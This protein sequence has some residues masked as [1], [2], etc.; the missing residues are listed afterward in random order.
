[1]GRWL[2]ARAKKSTGDAI[3]ALMGL[4]ANTARVLRDGQEID[5]PIEQVAV[6]DIVRFAPARRCRSM[7]RDVGHLNARRACSRAKAF[8]SKNGP[9]TGDRRDDQRS[10]SFLFRRRRSDRIPRSRRLSALVE[11][12]QG[13]KAPMQRLADRISGIFVPVV[14]IAALTFGIWMLVGPERSLY[15]VTATVAV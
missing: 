14:L 8:R 10:G 12:A 15:A 4:Q 13:S 6:G 9:V 2:E 1:M 11:D 3:R 7:P 5:I